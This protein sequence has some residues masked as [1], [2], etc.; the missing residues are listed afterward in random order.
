MTDNNKG[1]P[2]KMLIIDDDMPLDKGYEWIPEEF[3]RVFQVDEAKRWDCDSVPL[4]ERARTKLLEHKYDIILLD[5][6]LG[7][8]KKDGQKQ[9][10]SGIPIIR[11]IRKGIKG[12]DPEKG[13]QNRNT[14]V[15]GVSN[16][17]GED[18]FAP[19]TAMLDSYTGQGRTNPVGLFEELKKF[20]EIRRK[21]MALTR[22][23]GEVV[24]S[25]LSKRP[26]PGNTE[27][28]RIKR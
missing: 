27:K 25:N 20:L 26:V 22:E 16:N 8:E 17:W 5:F 2:I 7:T 15:I 9:G 21:A 19:A 4:A 12:A 3:P 14:Y 28:R 1:Q 13:L 11:Q 18:D 6:V 23:P 10:M 24:D